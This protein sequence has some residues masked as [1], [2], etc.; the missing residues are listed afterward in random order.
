[1]TH[2]ELAR[3]YLEYLRQGDDDSF[4]A[5]IDVENLVREE[6]YEAWELI[7]TLV[8]LA[9]EDGEALGRIGAGPLEDLL[10]YQPAPIL[11]W[12]E[13]EA[14]QNAAFAIANFGRA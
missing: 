12:A 2:D 11:E 5:Y 6:P 4:Q 3:A 14:S 1:M 9:A 10:R 8:Q 7:L 13:A